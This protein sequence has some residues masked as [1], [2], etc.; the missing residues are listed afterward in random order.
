MTNWPDSAF[1]V[2]FDMVKRDGKLV[3]YAF[4]MG[5]RYFL[6]GCYKIKYKEKLIFATRYV[7]IHF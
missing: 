5:V 6:C 4:S 7:N 3:I 1:S 2:S